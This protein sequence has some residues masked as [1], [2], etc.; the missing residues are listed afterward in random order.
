MSDKASFLG[1]NIIV[2]PDDKAVLERALKS[3]QGDLFDEIVVTMA[4]PKED[5]EIKSLAESLGAKVYFFKWNSNFSDA[6]NYSFSKNTS[7]YIFWI[8]SDDV[9]KPSE[10][11]KLQELK[12]HIRTWDIVVMDYV[13]SHD[14]KDEPVLILPRERIVKNCDSIKWHDPIHEYMNLDVPPH[15][16]NR[17]KVRIDHYRMS[18]HNPARNIESLKKVY[19]SK[20][21]SERI[22][23]Y[24]GKELADY[25][26]WDK[27]I[28][29]LE[30]YI[31]DGKDFH[32]NLTNACIRLARYY[33][34]KR[35]YASAKTYALK[36]VRF[37]S[38]YAEN[39]VIL[40]NI[41]EHE[42]DPDTAASYYKEA[43]NK[44]LDGGMSQIVD[45]YGFIPA[46]KLALLYNARKEYDNGIKYCELALKH[47]PDD[48]PMIE[49][50]KMMKIEVE[51][52][53]KGSVLKEDDIIEIQKYLAG[54]SLNAVVVRNN[55]DFSDLRINRIRNLEV[56]WLVPNLDLNNP[57]TRI[58]RYNIHN[59][60][61]EMCVKS[62]LIT[63]YYD[64]SIHE[65]RNMVGD[66]SVV[67]FTQFSKNDLEIM[68]HLK[69]SD[70]K[71]VFD[72]CEAL[73]NYPF[74][75][76]CMREVSLITCCSTKLMEITNEYGFM[77]TAVIKDSFEIASDRTSYA[78]RYNKPKAV[79]L[80]MGGNSWIVNEW[81]KDTIEEA[82]YDLITITEWDNATK[83]WSQD[84]WM[85]DLIECDVVLCPQ[86]VDVQPAKSSVKAT[87]AMAL[88][89][90]VICS[91]LQAYKEIIIQGENGFICDTKEEWKEALINLKDP[92]LRMKIGEAGKKSVEGYSLYN[93]TGK[94]VTTLTDLIND[95]LVFKD[96]PAN[97]ETKD[98]PIVDI[99]IA[100]YNNVEYLKMCINSIQMN[101]LH[102]YHIIISDGGSNEEVWEYL[103]NL[104]GIT[105]IGDKSIRLSFSETCNAGIQASTT[106]YFVI[107]NSDVI[108]SKCWLTSLVEK[109][110]TEDRLASCGVLSNCDRGWLHSAPGKPTY[111]MTLEKSGI[112]LH[113]AMKIEEIKPYVEELYKFMEESNKKFKG[114]FVRQDWVAA[115][116]TIFARCAINEVGLFDPTYINNAEDLDLMT[117]LN[118]FGYKTGQA[119]DS[120]VF[121]FGG[122]S[123]MYR[124]KEDK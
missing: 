14:E 25:G 7:E 109:M 32:D 35:D 68:K 106:K 75:S 81:L 103:R 4:M 3:C 54:R 113:P 72:H 63:N 97:I 116:A 38:I 21:C 87:T 19:E 23:F 1:L 123:R 62:I 22:K 52:L 31:K 20:G 101:T 48:A 80:G 93:I 115:Y 112:D 122:I 33:L 26:I 8:D 76:E 83:R 95:R 85:N 114:I 111:P 49:L 11:K 46:A 86:R 39:Y 37:N 88:G 107:L 117:R 105:V 102:P 44:R 67:I 74:E 36:G 104:K 41:F 9:I 119:I 98:R 13:Y 27:A 56:V 10:Y 47:K 82:G 73:F 69:G 40:G 94:W 50:L 70:I 77:N 100:S 45:Y 60:L 118:K 84:T 55:Y 43:L 15:K 66:A 51:R 124:E 58:R 71:C 30:P 42:N 28:K 99:I 89:M 29:V 65:I 78:K 16:L 110:E 57:S 53:S 34:E 61:N 108:V 79:Y 24:Y 92:D 121:H 6:R 59:K 64:N 120:F 5:P 17:I 91:P 2:G 18:S 96:P 12:P 90:P